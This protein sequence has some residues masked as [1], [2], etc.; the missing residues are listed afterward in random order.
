MLFYGI[1]SW[2]YSGN[3]QHILFTDVDRTLLTHR[4]E[5][6]P[7]IKRAFALAREA[8]LKIVFVTARAPG[9]LQPIAT[10]LGNMGLCCCFGGGWIGDLGSRQVED[11][12][13]LPMETALSIMQ[14]AQAAG[15]LPV[16]YDVQ[17]VYAPTIN[18]VVEKQLGNVGE[19]AVP[20]S[21]VAA[22]L[23]P[24]KIMVIDQRHDPVLNAIAAD[25][26]HGATVS[27]S[28][29]HLLEV[30]PKTVDKGTG[31][32]RIVSLMG[33]PG[34]TTHAAGDAQ[35]DIPLLTAAKHRYTVANGIPELKEMSEF[36]GRSCN[37]AGL[38]DVIDYIT[39]HHM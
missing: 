17:D 4:Y 16:W 35:N 14:M 1:L 8:A 39:A 18:D 29:P 22:L 21:N 5:V 3:M 2:E 31:L 10:S 23:P 36:V 24:M 30:G 25:V 20:F 11:V 13:R 6:L 9:S 27:F 12:H 26:A 7:Q 37:E 15:A 38:A 33:P 32:R 34:V 19:R 28:H